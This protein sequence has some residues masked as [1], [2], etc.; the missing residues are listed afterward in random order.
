MNVFPTY[1]GEYEINVMW[2]E[3]KLPSC[4]VIGHAVAASSPTVPKDT[5]P[6]LPNRDQIILTGHG[7][8]KARTNRQAEF[9]IDATNA[10][11]G[12]F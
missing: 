1:V 11:Q 7:L 6:P 12:N 9:V 10:A 5:P 8:T 4:P 3:M 2:N